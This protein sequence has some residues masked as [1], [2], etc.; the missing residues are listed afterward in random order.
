MTLNVNNILHILHIIYYIIYYIIC[1]LLVNPRIYKILYCG[2]TLN[3]YCY[4]GFYEQVLL[5][6]NF[7]CVKV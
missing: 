7:I 6:L 3:D 4:S 2:Q 1:N 5:L